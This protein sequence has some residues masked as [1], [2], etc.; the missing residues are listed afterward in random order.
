MSS[1]LN[2]N[3]YYNE[4]Y[5]LNNIYPCKKN[6]K[7]I[8]SINSIYKNIFMIKRCIYVTSRCNFKN[9]HNLN[10]RKENICKMKRKKR[11][12]YY[13]YLKY[14]ININR[15]NVKCLY[16]Q[17]A[18][19]YLQ[20]YKK[21]IRK[22]VKNNKSKF[23]KTYLYKKL[24]HSNNVKNFKLL[25]KNSHNTNVIKCEKNSENFK[26]DE[27]KNEKDL[28]IKEKMN[29]YKD[30]IIY[31]N[32]EM[33]L[34][35]NVDENFHKNDDKNSYK[36]VGE[37]KVKNTGNTMCQNSYKKLD[38]NSKD[39]DKHIEE[40]THEKGEMNIKINDLILVALSGCIPFICFGFVDNSFMIIAGDLFDST[41]CI[42]LGF[43]TM[44]AAGLGNLTSDVLGI[45]IGGY[46]EKI[47]VYIGF[48]RINLTNKQLKMNRT[49]RYYYVG[50][51]LGIAIG[52]LLGMIPLLFIDNNKLEEKKNREKKK[53]KHNKFPNV[54]K[55]L[56]EFVSS[57]IPKYI[58]SNYAFLFIVDNNNNNFYSYINNEIIHLSLDEGVIGEVYKNKKAINCEVN[59]Q[60]KN[61]VYSYKPNIKDKENK[62]HTNDNHHNGGFS[63]KIIENTNLI[64]NKEKIDIQQIIAAPVF[65]LDDSIIGVVVVINV[66]DK[67]FFNNK[68]VEFL[69]LFC[70]HISQEIEDERDL[71][72]TLK[73]CKKIVYD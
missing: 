18:L 47:I 7:N 37:N 50:S 53:K 65:G 17:K 62:N 38:Q 67:L 52:C 28:F 22:N 51:A 42:F 44:A 25:H 72:K 35:N 31:E 11:K 73:L 32:N 59:N 19:R 70:S 6:I 14:I 57:E 36:K 24:Y 41:F 71:C 49:R 48:P 66:K 26:K 69:N 9:Q 39:F 3:I 16:L 61:T 13:N 64:L 1:S 56:F 5:Q 58:N 45:F 60:L 43:S 8:N 29:S 46:I 12:I 68:D 2:R 40:K 23:E 63:V 34:H 10:R 4:F 15:S 30:D 20:N 54:N 33:N 27:T 55:K 21:Y